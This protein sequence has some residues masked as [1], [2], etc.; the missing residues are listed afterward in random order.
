MTCTYDRA[1]IGSSGKAPTP[2]TAGE[3]VTDLHQLLQTADVP[4][5]HV[6]VG[7]SAGGFLVQL[8]GRRYS[9][10][11]EGVV[12]MSS[13]HPAHPWLE[14]ALPRFNDEERKEELTFYRGENPE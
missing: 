13:V 6:L 3:I 4:G 14:R 5:P 9:D 2:R 11:V 7:H 1:N 8:C 12:A 10:E